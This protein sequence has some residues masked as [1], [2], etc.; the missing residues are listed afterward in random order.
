MHPISIDPDVM[1]RS[2]FDLTP[3]CKIPLH[4]GSFITSD[5]FR[6]YCPWASSID[7]AS[8]CAPKC[9]QLLAF[10][11]LATCS[12]GFHVGASRFP[13]LHCTDDNGHV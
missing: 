3:L 7:R 4:G 8:F 5:S 2:R 12:G 9:D 11:D 13:S 10:P 1:R 6:F